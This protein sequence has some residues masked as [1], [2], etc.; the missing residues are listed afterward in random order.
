MDDEYDF[1]RQRKM[2]QAIG[3]KY[4]ESRRRTRSRSQI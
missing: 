4:D 3:V 1:T 2:A